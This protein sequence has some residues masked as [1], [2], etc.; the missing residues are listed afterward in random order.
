MSHEVRSS[1]PRSETP[2]AERTSWP[3]ILV[4]VVLL[5]VVGSAWYVREHPAASF[6]ETIGTIGRP[7]AMT[8]EA[9]AEGGSSIVGRN[10]SIVDAR[11]TGVASA[12]T[13]WVAGSEGPPLLVVALPTA[14]DAGSSRQPT[15]GIKPGQVVQLNGVVRDGPREGLSADDQAQLKKASVYLVAAEILT[16][17][18]NAY[19]VPS[20][21]RHA[22]R[23]G[24]LRER[25][26]PAAGQ[27]R[28][29][30]GGRPDCRRRPQCPPERSGPRAA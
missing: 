13:F 5:V 11:V 18:C 30:P 7:D 29:H 4:I 15:V 8:V 20:A 16:P 17:H 2:R 3:W 1:F 26:W 9:I 10:V 24:R 28:H 6:R 12:H 14:L 19:F 25:A 22:L 27:R 21:R 23:T